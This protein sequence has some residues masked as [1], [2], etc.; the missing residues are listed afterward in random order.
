MFFYIHMQTEIIML[1]GKN[2]DIIETQLIT[3][4]RIENFKYVNEQ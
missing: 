2:I 4:K 1:S 3:V